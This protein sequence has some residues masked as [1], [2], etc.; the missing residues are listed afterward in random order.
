MDEKVRHDTVFDTGAEHLGRVYAEALLAAAQTGGASDQVVDQL[1]RLVDDVLDQHPTLA[2][3][4]ASPR[5]DFEEK[6]R[7]IDRLFASE[8]HPT[9]LQF[10]KVVARRERLG[11]LRQIA[12][13]AVAIR[14][15]RSGRLVAEVR[16]AVPLT[17][18]LRQAVVARLGET[19]NQEIVL[20]EVVDP[21]LIGGLL[22]R[23]GDTVFDSSVSNRLSRMARKTRQTFARQM[24]ENAGRF[25]V[26][27]PG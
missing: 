4:F 3:A 17:D 20:R 21:Q 8:V 10:L 19:M 12:S 7:I 5:V 18:E 26:G 11:Y 9:L 22:I 6:Q 1:Q 15:E 25:A 23:I 27:T 16:S 13:A 2:A 24:L 14:D